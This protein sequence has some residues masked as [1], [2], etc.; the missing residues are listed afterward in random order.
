MDKKSTTSKI[1]AIVGPTAAG[2]SAWAETLQ[3]IFKGEI[4]SADSRQV[5][6]GMDIGTAKPTSSIQKK[7][8]YHL[9]DVLAPDQQYTL[10]DF[11]DQAAEAVQDIHSR[12]RLPLIVGGTGLYVEALLD[13]YKLSPVGPA[14][15]TRQALEKESLAS[16][17]LI[18]ERAHILIPTSDQKNKRRLIRA[19]ERGSAAAPARQKT[20]YDTLR[21]GVH[22]PKDILD[23]NIRRRV[24]RMFKEGLVDEVQELLSQYSPTAPGLKTI[25][26][27]EVINYIK[28]KGTLA[29]TQEQIVTHTRQYAKRQ[30]TWF[31]RDKRIEW[32]DSVGAAEKRIAQWLDSH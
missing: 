26:Y 31:R 6:R 32:L 25:G 10:F 29:T 17:Q 13:G 1:V 7:H 12:H 21:I 16:L 5:Y 9:I 2:K 4:I 20:Q 11:L 15:D 3:P 18:A 8:H 27:A 19:L 14:K 30:M 24:W 28:G 23:K 22:V